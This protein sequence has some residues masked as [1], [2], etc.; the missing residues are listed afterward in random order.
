M[1][2]SDVHLPRVAADRLVAAL[3]RER[4]ARRRYLAA[5][6]AAHEVLRHAQ[7]R[8]AE[9]SAA[10]DAH[11]GVALGIDAGDIRPHLRR[12]SGT[13]N[14]PSTDRTADRVSRSVTRRPAPW[15]GTDA[16]SSRTALPTLSPEPSRLTA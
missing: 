10:I 2:R 14:R 11:V 15:Q 3:A 4:D 8:F 6:T 9:G 12:A 13:E 1:R 5:I 7:E 16:E